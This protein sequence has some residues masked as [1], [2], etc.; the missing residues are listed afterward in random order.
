M[1]LIESYESNRLFAIWWLVWAPSSIRFF[2]FTKTWVV[3][4]VNVPVHLY[5]KKHSQYYWFSLLYGKYVYY[6]LNMKKVFGFKWHCSTMYRRIIVSASIIRNVC[7][8]SKC[9]LFGL[10]TVQQIIININLLPRE[11]NNKGS[12]KI[13]RHRTVSLCRLWLY[14]RFFIKTSWQC[15]CHAYTTIRTALDSFFT[16]TFGETLTLPSK[17]NI[18][19]LL[20]RHLKL[21]SVDLVWC[22]LSLQILDYWYQMSGMGFRCP[23]KCIEADWVNKRPESVEKKLPT[24][25]SKWQ[26]MRGRGWRQEVKDRGGGDRRWD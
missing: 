4:Y 26:D 6:L 3:A 18:P 22:S 21:S 13:N 24:H 11:I 17:H 16:F 8:H 2:L 5:N 7:S 10:K 9:H 25:H 20:L 19:V 23:V 14:Q 15:Y 1:L 12:N